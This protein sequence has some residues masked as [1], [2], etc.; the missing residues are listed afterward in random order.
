MTP[1]SQL[2]LAANGFTLA[3]Q[4]GKMK[5]TQE[6]SMAHLTRLLLVGVAVLSISAIASGQGKRSI[7]TDPIIKLP[8]D[9]IISPGQYTPEID[10]AE[11][12]A[13]RARIPAK[14]VLSGSDNRHGILIAISNVQLRLKPLGGPNI[15]VRI[16]AGQTRWIDNMGASIENLSAESCEFLFIESKR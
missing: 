11:L 9:I 12:R 3:T 2:P 8:P 16:R 5:P 15:D 7:V 6:E 13:M 4:G 14:S 1:G 10:N